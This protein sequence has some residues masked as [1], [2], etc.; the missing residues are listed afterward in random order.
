MNPETDFRPRGCPGGQTQRH[1]AFSERAVLSAR[2]DQPAVPHFAGQRSGAGHA[3]QHG[4]HGQ[5]TQRC[6]GR[7]IFYQTNL[8][9]KRFTYRVYHISLFSSRKKP[10]PP[11]VK[12]S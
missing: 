4:G 2:R 5:N 12:L 1:P 10:G 7:V 6:N 8:S 9:L 3:Q 11:R